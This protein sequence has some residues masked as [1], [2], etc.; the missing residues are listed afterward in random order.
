LQDPPVEEEDEE[1]PQ[2]DEVLPA[3]KDK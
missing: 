1:D 3:T 2:W